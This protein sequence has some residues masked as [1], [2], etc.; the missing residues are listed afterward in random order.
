ML[1]IR[2]ETLIS[3]TQA[4]RM[5]PPGRRERP[6]SVSCV[7]RW[8]FS[9]IKTPHGK[10]RLEGIRIGGR[11][12]TSVEALERF[13]AAQTPDLA[14]RPQLPRTSTMRCR[15]AQRAEAQLTKIGI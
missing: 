15:A 13:A 8:I 7:Y 3:L 4:A 14:D 5:L 11:W 12:L 2:N 10:V 1:D 6:V 9:G